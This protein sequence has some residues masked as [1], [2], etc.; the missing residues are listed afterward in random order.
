VYP[1]GVKNIVDRPV[2]IFATT[3]KRLSRVHR[4]YNSGSFNIVRLSLDERGGGP[5]HKWTI[6]FDRAKTASIIWN[7]RF[8]DPVQPA[9]PFA[10]LNGTENGGDVAGQKFRA[11]PGEKRQT[12]DQL[13]VK[14]FN[15]DLV[16][17]PQLW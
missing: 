5:K 3:P 11:K 2:R 6:L 4:P 12:R 13:Q 15:L 10:V 16:R 9:L 17:T 7:A 8:V 14:S 1:N